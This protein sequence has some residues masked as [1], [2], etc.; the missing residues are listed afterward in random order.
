M[1]KHANAAVQCDTSQ[2]MSSENK[3]PKLGCQVR[4]Q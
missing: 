1:I 2:R 3:Y 4:R